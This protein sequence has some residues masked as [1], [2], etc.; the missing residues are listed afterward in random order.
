MR[1]KKRPASSGVVSLLTDFGPGSVY[2]GQMHATILRLAPSSRVVDLA[3]DCPFGNTEAAGYILRRSYPHFP[4]G[5]VHVVVVDPGVGS[6]RAV[7]VAS[8]AGH[9]FVAP[10]TGVLGGVLALDPAA[11]VRRVEKRTLMNDRISSTFH[12]R[13]ILAP[14]AARLATGTDV[15][16][17][18]PA[19]TPRAAPP[20]PAREG[21]AFVGSVLLV[22]RFG[23]LITNI[24]ASALDE[25]GGPGGV[26]LRIGAAFIDTVA[27]TFSDV[28]KGVALV[29]VGSGDHIEVAVNEGRAADALRMSVGDRVRLERRT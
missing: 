21:E 15:E 26:R 3:H 1:R 13:D 18:G 23:N 24:P 17:F 8:A 5:T 22:D 7:L 20:G 2:V 6:N 25:M 19:I 14:A 16:D 12:G 27:T 11:V 9:L 29:Y 10:D 28:P 4:E